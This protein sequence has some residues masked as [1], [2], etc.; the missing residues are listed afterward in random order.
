MKK[1]GII[2][3]THGCFDEPLREFLRDVDE[4]W[5]AGDIGSLEL[6]DRIAAFKPLRAVCGNIDDGVTRRVYPP[7]LAFECEGVR[8]LMT[9]IGGYPRRYDPR[10]VQRIQALHP[11]LFISGH[12]HI[13][14]VIYDPVYEMLTVNPGAA[15]EYGF[16][17][18]RTA[19][20]LT[21]EAGEMRDME[22]GE[23]PRNSVR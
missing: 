12:S 22:V 6:A 9:H 2:S 17:R 18:V 1:I 5:H 11:K 21:V 4:I 15:G 14:K 7:F 23:W 13:L 10:A 19:I 8:V 20:R 3:D 16:H